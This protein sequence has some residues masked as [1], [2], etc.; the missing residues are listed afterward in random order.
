MNAPSHARIACA[1]QGP[2]F[3]AALLDPA[4]ETPRG[5][6]A[7]NGSDPA[8]RF[9]VYRNN[10]MSSLVDALA[11]AFPVVLRL[12]GEPFFRAMAAEFVR[13]S[14]PRSRVLAHY[15]HDL[16]SFIGGFEP[17]RGLPYLPDVA[18]LEIARVHA[19]HAADVPAVSAAQATA[20]LASGERA[21]ELR[22]GIHPSLSTIESAFA[23]VSLWHA[24]Q[25]V[26]EIVPI[27][28]DHPEGAVVMRAGLDVL[29]LP[30]PIG[31]TRFV[32]SIRDGSGL[33]EAATIAGTADCGFDLAATLA[34]LVRYGALTQLLLPPRSLP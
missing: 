30:A 7:W 26:D 12:V 15:G 8:A 17:A 9:A 13:R 27:D 4:R 3:A 31:A 21:G 23:V 16:P 34:M 28:V 11:D 14:P 33:G 25:G 10:V 22:V 2:A 29:V 20:A 18:R 24:H 32:R 1:D 5:L 19:F 6:R